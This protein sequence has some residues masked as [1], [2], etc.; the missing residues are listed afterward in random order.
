MTN[1]LDNLKPWWEGILDLCAPIDD[2]VL[3]VQLGGHKN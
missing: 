1:G 3:W 2:G